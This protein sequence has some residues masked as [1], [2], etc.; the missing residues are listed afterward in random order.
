MHA[1]IDT[2]IPEFLASL[3]ALFPSRL[4]F[5][6]LQGSYGRGEATDKSDIDVVVI[7]D[8]AKPED[9]RAYSKMLDT[10]P[11]RDKAC[12]FI[13][14]IREL[15][16]WERSDLFQFYHDTTPIYGSLD[17]LPDKIET[18]DIRRAVRIG[19]CSIYHVCGHN[20]VHE[21]SCEM[22][23]GLYKSA[24]FTVQAISYLL[25]GIYRKRKADLLP[26]LMPP[27]RPILETAMALGQGAVFAPRDFD[28][29]SDLL[30]QWAS[31]VIREYA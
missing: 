22:L 21:R 1:K 28:R 12:G 18:E 26:L 20:M 27:D 9:L 31:S 24:V 10:L 14:G 13:S 19:A 11:Y 6:G 29:L 2:W 16:N 5:V 25:T 8:E 7:L 15:E 30:F 23:K 3:K 4:I 17:F